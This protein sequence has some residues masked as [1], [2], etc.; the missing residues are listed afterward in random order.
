MRYTKTTLK[1]IEAL[2]KEL[3][4][5]VRY[6]KGNFVSGYAVVESKKVAVINRFYDTE[7]RINAL[8]EILTSIEVD[9]SVLSDEARD[10]YY[11]TQVA[12]KRDE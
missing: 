12:G 11:L 10:L 7:A 8:V 6:E 1:K 4:Y 3:G 2:F 9:D 5:T